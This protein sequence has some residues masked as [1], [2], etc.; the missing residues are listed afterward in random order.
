MV[1]M[2]DDEF[3]PATEALLNNA[4]IAKTSTAKITVVNL[5]P[6]EDDLFIFVFH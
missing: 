2:T 1:L 5:K 3:S 6:R 4:E